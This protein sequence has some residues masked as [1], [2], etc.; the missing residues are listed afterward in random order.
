MSIKR[1]QLYPILSLV[2]ILLLSS[3]FAYAFETLETKKIVREYKKAVVQIVFRWTL[4]NVE[5]GESCDKTESG[6]G[7][8]IS[9]DGYILTAEH[10]IG[11]G[12]IDIVDSASKMLVSLREIIVITYDGKTIQAIPPDP[13]P[14]NLG[15]DIGILKID[16][17]INLP[18]VSI[19]D[20]DSLELGEEVVVLGYPI[21]ELTVTQGIIIALS[22]TRETFRI[23]IGVSAG[24]S[25]SPVLNSDGKVIGIATFSGRGS[26]SDGKLA[27]L[28]G[29]ATDVTKSRK[30]I[31][32]F[33]EQ[34]RSKYKK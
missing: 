10:V 18:Y 29:V 28:F 33:I 2:L 15:V 17:A 21:P 20:V 3:K 14:P 8:I 19:A 26:A 11:Q 27:A 16:K 6:S 4:S 13:Y 22:P 31:L 32:D 12:M 5:S 7:F 34:H 23:S 24:S 1:G 9:E 25:G 30:E